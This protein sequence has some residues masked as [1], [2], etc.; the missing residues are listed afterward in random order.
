[1]VYLLDTNACSRVI[2]G[3]LTA[4]STRWFKWGNGNLTILGSVVPMI[5]RL[6]F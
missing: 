1:M 2:Q 6:L 4:P 3:D 5:S